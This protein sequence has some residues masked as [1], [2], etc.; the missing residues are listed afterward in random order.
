M[1]FS[2][3]VTA[4]SLVRHCKKES[5]WLTFCRPCWVYLLFLLMFDSGLFSWCWRFVDF[6]VLPCTAELK[7]FLNTRHLNKSQLIFSLTLHFKFESQIHIFIHATLK[8][9]FQFTFSFILHTI[10]SQL[11]IFIHAT[12]EILTYH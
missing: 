10:E 4:T 3:F 9:E 5:I 7:N 11:H 6:F 8:I 2:I 1:V 12:L